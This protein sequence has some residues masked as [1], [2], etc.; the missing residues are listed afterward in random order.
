M[1]QTR[2]RSLR[3]TTS[4]YLTVALGVAALG[5]EPPPPP[6]T[7]SAQSQDA[8]VL[9][10]WGRV[11]IDPVTYS[12]YRSSS[13]GGPY[14]RLSNVGENRYYK[15]REVDIGGTYFYVVTAES[16]AGD[17][18]P[19]SAEARATVYDHNVVLRIEVPGGAPGAA[20]NDVPLWTIPVSE[21]LG[22]FVDVEIEV[23]LISLMEPCATDPS[24]C[25]G[26]E[27]A[28]DP[29]RSPECAGKYY[30]VDDEDNDG[31]DLVDQHDPDCW[32]VFRWR[33]SIATDEEFHLQEVVERGTA[34][35]LC[36]R[37][38][39]RRDSEGGNF[40]STRIVDPA[41][42]EGQ[43]GVLAL[44]ALSFYATILDPLF[45][46]PILKVRGRLLTEGLRESGDVTEPVLVHI[47]EPG[48]TG[49]TANG[50]T[51]STGVDVWG[52]GAIQ[53]ETVSAALQLRL[54]GSEFSRGDADADGATNIA[55]GIYLLNHL[56]L[57]GPPPPCSDSADSD[58]SGVLDLSDAIATFGFL[59]LG[60]TVPPSPG[61][62]DCG[63]DPTP[64]TLDCGDFSPCT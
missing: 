44:V 52:V 19:F 60:D 37:P 11:D 3:Q 20:V 53:P 48:E 33:Y 15:D 24:V 39:G 54:V 21:P 7:I 9:V 10:S 16:A 36:I 26:A 1:W 64:D 6:S 47:I 62:F 22:E 13:E 45:E 57:G 4:M 46:G 50:S 32:G 56:F 41:E 43:E 59:F 5:G 31:D 42:N 49:L 63:V 12:V 27:G 35:D 23:V 2:I 38:P 8:A 30:C 29:S 55:D 34:S 25:E 17:E 58:D 61:P 14:Q 28:L 51:G 40:D 18:S